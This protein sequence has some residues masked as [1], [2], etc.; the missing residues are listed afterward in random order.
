MKKKAKKKVAVKK[1]KSK[2]SGKAPGLD[3]SGEHLHRVRSLCMSLPGTTEK[4]SHGAPTFFAAKVYCMFV[5]NHHHDGHLAVWI[6]AEPGTQE[7]LIRADAR[8]YFRPPYEGVKGWIGIELPQISDD[9]LGMHLTEAYRL[10]APKKRAQ[11]QSPEDVTARLN[12]IYSRED[13]KLDPALH[14]AQMKSAKKN[15]PW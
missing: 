8:K 1:A 11:S 14:E 5:D 2:M 3:Y 12:E 9:G 15:D 4:L 6:P 7:A 10:I 13:S